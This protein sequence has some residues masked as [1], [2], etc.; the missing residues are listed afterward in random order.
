LT[1]FLVDDIDQAVAAVHAAQSLDRRRI[2]TRFSARFSARRM[3]AD[4]LALYTD[5]AAGTVSPPMRSESVD[6]QLPVLSPG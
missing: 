6:R 3:A 4:Y 5:L 2:R 1:G